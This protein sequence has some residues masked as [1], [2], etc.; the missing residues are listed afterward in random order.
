MLIDEIDNFRNMVMGKLEHGHP[1]TVQEFKR[2]LENAAARV[3]L[4]REK[5]ELRAGQFTA[6]PTV[7][8]SLTHMHSCL[9]REGS[10]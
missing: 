9:C 5:N 6:T 3:V 7:S 10:P 4:E 2:G 8:L 1:I